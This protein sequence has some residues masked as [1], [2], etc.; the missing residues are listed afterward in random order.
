MTTAL[1]SPGHNP[2]V[3]D[4]SKAMA[5][6]DTLKPRSRSQLEMSVRTILFNVN[7]L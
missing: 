1:S 6:K 5:A 4:G 2:I 3:V 7:H